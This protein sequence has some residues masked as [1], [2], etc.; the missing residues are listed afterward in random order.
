[1]STVIKELLIQLM[2]VWRESFIIQG[3]YR[4]W[5]H[6][7]SDIDKEGVVNPKPPKD[8]ICS[9]ECKSKLDV[10]KRKWH[11]LWAFRRERDYRNLE[12][13]ASKGDVLVMGVVTKG[14]VEDMKP[15]GGK[16]ESG[17]KIVVVGVVTQEDLVGECH[18]DYWPEETGW[19]YK[20]FIRVLYWLPEE[21]YGDGL[22]HE[23]PF[24]GSLI[25]ITHADAVE[26]IKNLQIRPYKLGSIDLADSSC[27]TIDAKHVKTDKIYLD[28]ET[29][30]FAVAA[31]KAGNLLLVGP[32]GVGKTTLARALAEALGSGY[33][34]AVAHAL[35][36]RRD[37]VGGETIINNTVYWRSGLLI[38][39]YNRAAERIMNGDYRPYFLIID[40]INRADADKAFADF[41]AAF[42]SPFC[43]DWSIPEGLVEEI[44]S[45]GTYIDDEAKNFIN[46]Y[47]LFRDIPLKFIRIIGTMNLRDA[48]NLFM[49]GEALLRRFVIVKVDTDAC[50]SLDT[51]VRDEK[52]RPLFR[53]LCDRDNSPLRG[54]PPAAVAGA[55][56]LL[57]ALG[58]GQYTED[59]VRRALEALSGKLPGGRRSG[60]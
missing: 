50:R 7:L 28:D 40:E 39:A 11:I 6:S 2:Q 30:R 54:M 16:L 56:K 33:H 19:K 29:L 21:R 51:L 27:K 15:K 44:K 46:Y 52:M 23:K 20:F 58:G 53:E 13:A 43:E 35:W 18:C 31:A 14:N 59:D 5:Y 45:Y 55:A 25:P 36:F 34:L 57:E 48:R 8:G 9:E 1:M 4:N 38:R 3:S 42:I 47:S 24:P 17:R 41:F 10:K 32:P 37:V 12:E 26:I 49:L 22:R 60:R